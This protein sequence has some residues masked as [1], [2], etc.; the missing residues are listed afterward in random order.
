[1]TNQPAEM[2]TID[3]G[4]GAM[5]A[6]LWRPA[7]GIGPG[8]VLVHEI[9]GISDY[10]Q[11]RGRDLA[12]LG[13][14]V[15]APEVYWRLDDREIDESRADVLQQ[16]ISVAQRIDW[17]TAV[18]DLQA[19][20]S[21]VRGMIEVEGGVG[22]L[23]FCFGG[24]LAFNVA[25]Q[26]PAD[27]LVSY[28]GSALPELLGVLP[29]DPSDVTLTVIDPARVTTPSLHHWGLADSF[30]DRPVVEQVCARLE[31]QP[32]VTVETY[33][34]GGHAFDND[35]FMFYDAD[36]AALAWQRTLAFLSDRL[37]RQLG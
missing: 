25:A 12:A 36:L 31:A 32:D 18:S 11:S 6:Q 37:P 2:I 33:E 24:G 30:I 3:T 5:P 22:L 26:S 23:G 29:F 7:A 10:I 4:D 14:L 28:Y 8:L 9:F 19:A 1:M 35:D 16:A 20:L 27:A 34:G 17:P 15:C 13:Y 21:H